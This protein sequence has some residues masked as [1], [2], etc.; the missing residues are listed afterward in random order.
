MSYRSRSPL[1]KAIA[2]FTGVLSGALA[3]WACGPFFPQ[4]LLTQESDILEA[5]TVWL[6]DALA[7]LPADQLPSRW[8]WTR[9]GGLHQTAAATAG[10]GDRPRPRCRA[11]AGRRSSI[12]MRR[13]GMPS[14]PAGA[15]AS[16]RETAQWAD[17]KP[18]LPQ[19]PQLSVLPACRENSTTICAAPSPITRSRWTPPAPLGEKLLARPESE[20]RL[21]STWAAFM[22][23]KAT[24]DKE[25][26]AAIRWFE[27][28]RELA[29]KGF[30]DP[31]GLAE[32]SLGWQARAEAGLHHPEAALK[33]YLQQ[34]KAGDL[35]ALTS[36]RQ[37]CARV[38]AEPAALQRVAGSAEARP[39]FTAWTL[40]VWTRDDY[41]GPLEAEGA[42]K[43]LAALRAAGVTRTDGADR[44][45]W[46]GRLPG[47]RLRRRRGLAEAG[48]GRRPDGTLD[49]RQAPA[50][51]RQGGR[52]GGAP[53]PG[54][55]RPARG[56]RPDHDLWEAY[57]S[58]V[59]PALRPRANGELGAAA[60]PAASTSTPLD[61]LLRGGYWT[62][63]AYLAERVLTVDELRAYVDK[64]WPPDLA[65]RYKPTQD[66]EGWG[67][68]TRAS[69]RRRTSAPPTTCAISW[70]AASSRPAAIP[71]PGP[72]S[73]IPRE[74]R[75]TR[76]S[77]R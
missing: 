56:S 24:V 44:L 57:E 22:L 34:E 5:P 48:A 12:R 45:A 32:A 60:S 21:R 46:P 64:T 23:G 1:A 54:G 41:D 36:I 10:P 74:R 47:R 68:T 11:T 65:A 19:P 17:P 55:H 37:T 73:P 26:A 33:L 28:T 14:S 16:W 70:D 27:R 30:P 39:I 61:D 62:D 29:G 69:P 50:A 66:G 38:L 49:T 77:K 7:P 43:W 67:L 3:L 4:W 59:R 25:R 15:G 20:R 72:I 13:C 9:K 8:W 2:V 52:S 71:K 40:S 35:T 51:R 42:R 6:R 63:A 76:S 18:P 31:L 53:R 75:W 58:N